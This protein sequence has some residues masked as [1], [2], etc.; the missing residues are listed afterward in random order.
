MFGKYFSSKLHVSVK[1][2]NAN[3]NL[4][5]KDSF[6][7]W[8]NSLNKINNTDEIYIKEFASFPRSIFGS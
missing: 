8:K 4:A 2:E 6:Q 5:P 3:K 7:Q 1:T